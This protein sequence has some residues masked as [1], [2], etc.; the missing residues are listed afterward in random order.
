MTTYERFDSVKQI[1]GYES[2]GPEQLGDYF[3]N[4]GLGDYREV[5]THHKIVSSKMCQ[6]SWDM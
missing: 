2:W 3:E 1:Q 5:L 6:I 4:Q